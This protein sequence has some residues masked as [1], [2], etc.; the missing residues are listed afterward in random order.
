MN[1]SI[2]FLI[3]YYINGN[4]YCSI[5]SS[6]TIL[7]SGML[8]KI[9]FPFQM[10]MHSL[11]FLEEVFF[12]DYLF[13]SSMTLNWILWG[14]FFL[15]P[16][17]HICETCVEIRLYLAILNVYSAQNYSCCWLIRQWIKYEVAAKTFYLP[18]HF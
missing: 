12:K 7:N 18:Y 17:L 15:P 14:F 4:I 13:W 8:F 1:L 9:F 3:I 11:I 10:Q 16:K 5:P 6:E 2:C